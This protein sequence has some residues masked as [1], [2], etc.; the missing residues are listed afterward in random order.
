MAQSLN[1]IQG[2]NLQ[3]RQALDKTFT[4][5]GES[6]KAAIYRHIEETC[7]AHKLESPLQTG[8]IEKIIDG[9]FGSGAASLKKMFNANLT[10]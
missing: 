9:V 7:N 5:L 4:V 8:D 2:S 3:L 6:P 10:G 1:P